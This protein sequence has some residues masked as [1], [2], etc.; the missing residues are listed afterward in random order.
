LVIF[1]TK[2][3]PKY[4]GRY[5]EAQPIANWTN[6]S[7]MGPCLRGPALELSTLD[8]SSTHNNTLQVLQRTSGRGGACKEIIYKVKL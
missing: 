8:C 7:Q 1:P 6:C 5:K 2:P 4:K 3:D